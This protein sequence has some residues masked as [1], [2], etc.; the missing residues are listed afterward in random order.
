MNQA[1][2]DGVL[3]ALNVGK[4]GGAKKLNPDDLGLTPDQV[5]EFISLGR[6]MLIPKDEQ[7]TFVQIEN[8]ARGA[9]E[10]E[11][12]AFPVGGA[13][14]V[15]RNRI[16]EIDAKL[17]EYRDVYMLAMESFIDR[18]A[19]IRDTTLEKYPDH[20]DKLEPFYPASHQIRRLFYFNWH[21]FE[22]G[23]AGGIRE[24]E[25]VEAYQR[26]KDNLK[27][28]FDKFLEDVVIDARFKVQET[29]MK[30]AERVARG[31]VVNGN[32]MKSLSN[33]IERF[34]ALNFVGDVKIEEQLQA[35]RDK[36]IAIDPKELKEKDD[37]KNQLGAMAANIAKDA[38]DISDVS[39]VTGTYKRRIDME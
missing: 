39:T 7:N 6:K 36:L 16:L 21:V 15:P 38:A 27:A 24:G 4:W 5:P 37:L 12:H 33:M 13:R 35:L 32:S 17:K 2:K 3:L 22:I 10:R 29:C 14:F 30:L 23:E 19:E 20:R 34:E 28:Q 26:F 11:S 18:Y 1:F 25:T 9:L 8:N 31:E